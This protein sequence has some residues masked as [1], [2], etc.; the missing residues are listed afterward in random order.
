MELGNIITTI[1]GG[2]MFPFL[3]S[4]MWG[5]LVEAFGPIG[6]WMAAAFIVGT[7]WAQIGRAHV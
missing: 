3:I 1:V 7:M 5:K 2:F 6:G 4:M